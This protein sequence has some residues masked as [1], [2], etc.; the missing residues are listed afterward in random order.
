MTSFSLL[1]NQFQDYVMQKDNA[2]SAHVIG[3]NKV[4]KEIRL[5]IY[6]NAYRLRL[7]EVLASSYPILQRYL[8]EEPFDQL[9]IDYIAA[10]PSNYRSIRWFGDQLSVFLQSHAKYQ[11]KPYL[12]EL[13]QWE[14]ISALVFDAANSAVLQLEQMA[15]VKA[16]LWETIKFAVVPSLYRL[17]LSWNVV[18]I[19]QAM[20]DEKDP[21][22]P[23]KNANSVA[24]VLWRKDLVIQYSSM[25]DDEASAL[26]VLIAGQSFGEICQG[27]CEFMDEA[28]VGLRAA[29]LLKGWINNGLIASLIL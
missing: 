24:W 23:E 2:I 28:D 15:A 4:P 17:N 16:D 7:Q 20:G 12:A 14:W 29:S 25:L 1:Q 21:V 9:C 5:S 6:E 27:L 11:K 8:G 18:P 3:T 13:A 26:D 19:W 10:F 22:Q